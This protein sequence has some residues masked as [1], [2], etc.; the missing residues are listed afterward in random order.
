MEKVHN[1]N[2]FLLQCE[3]STEL[4]TQQANVITYCLTFQG[5]KKDKRSI[6]NDIFYFYCNKVTNKQ[7]NNMQNRNSTIYRDSLEPAILTWCI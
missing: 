1:D 2:K 4:A 6:G 7:I 5:R 3:I